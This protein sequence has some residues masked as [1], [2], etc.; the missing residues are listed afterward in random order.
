MMGRIRKKLYLSA[1]ITESMRNIHSA[2]PQV[3]GP[4]KRKTESAFSDAP[5]LGMDQL[6]SL[7]RKGART[8]AHPEVDITAMLNWSFEEMIE[9]CKD[10][11]DEAIADQAGS[12]SETEEQAWLN[13]MEK[14]ETAVFEGKRHQ[15][16]IDKALADK[17]G[18]DRADR[19]IGKNTTVMIDGFAINKESLSCADWEAVPTMAGKDPSLA[20]PVREKKKPISNQEYCQHCWDGGKIVLCSGCPRSYHYDCL[21]NEFKAKTKGTMNFYC[22]QHN[23]VDCGAN[24]SNAGGMVSSRLYPIVRHR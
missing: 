13:T 22:Q 4:R 18:L 24:T 3:T 17:P 14:L 15:R 23:C 1:K 16:Q 12:I 21:S 11:S 7:L 10:K 5:E 9:Q 6:K 8:L 20:E 2:E 19:R